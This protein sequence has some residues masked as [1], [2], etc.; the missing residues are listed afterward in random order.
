MQRR[1]NKLLAEHLNFAQ[2]SPQV[3]ALYRDVAKPSP[4]LRLPGAFIPTHRSLFISSHNLYSITLA[5][6]SPMNA[7]SSHLLVIN[8][9][10][11]TSLNGSISDADSVNHP[12]L[13]S[14]ILLPVSPT[15]IGEIA[16]APPF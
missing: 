2:A 9:I 11:I 4:A 15:T 3:F 16:I 13:L 8:V 10:K 1:Y 14:K 12:I 5:T 6:A 7:L